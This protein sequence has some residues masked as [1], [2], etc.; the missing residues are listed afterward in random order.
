MSK[1]LVIN[2]IRINYE[3]SVDLLGKKRQNIED[4]EINE[5]SSTYLKFII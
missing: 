3:N 4:M 2:E 1:D 5:K